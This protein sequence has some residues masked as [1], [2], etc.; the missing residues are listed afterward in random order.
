MDPSF[1]IN[2]V[3]IFPE[4]F[5]SPLGVSLIGKALESKKI[6]VAFYDPK[7]FLGEGERIDD[8]PFGGGPGMV[9]RA[10]PVIRA[11]ESIPESKRGR[12]IAMSASGRRFTQ[13]DAEE[14]S[15]GTGVTIICG[16]YEGID[17]RA[18]DATGAVEY[19]VADC[20]LAGGEAGA[21]VVIE[22]TARL[23]PGFMGNLESPLQESHSSGLLEFPH[24]TRPRVVRGMPVPEVLLS[25]DHGAVARWRREQSLLKTANNR[26]DLLARAIREGRISKEEIEW[27]ETQ[28]VE[29]SELANSPNG[30]GVA[31][32]VQ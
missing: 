19:S 26:K 24:Y 25:G 6:A 2:I 9:M 14:L 22:S 5:E 10:E 11:V 18:L 8:Y 23:L 16:R 27:L 29:V 13:R 31:G 3:S 32:E 1:V 21:L 15:S 4:Y 12:I 20:V 17:Q 30:N 28:G 7:D